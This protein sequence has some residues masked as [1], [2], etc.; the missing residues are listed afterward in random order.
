MQNSLITD[1]D[2]R[3]WTKKDPLF[4]LKQLHEGHPGIC[5]IKSLARM[6]MWWPGMDKRRL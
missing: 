1:K 5:Y 2:I 4:S 6:Y 3:E